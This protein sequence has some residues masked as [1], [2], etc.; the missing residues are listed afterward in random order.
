MTYTIQSRAIRSIPITLWFYIIG[1]LSVSLVSAL[2]LFVLPNS[3]PQIH[4]VLWAL[5]VVV[6]IFLR[7]IYAK[8]IFL[9]W[10]IWYL[11]GVISY[12][13]ANAAHVGILSRYQADPEKFSLIYLVFL[14]AAVVGAY[15]TDRFY[16]GAH[17]QPTALK[18]RS[19]D[20]F[21][22]LALLVFSLVYAFT[23]YLGAGGFPILSGVNVSASMYENN[24]SPLKIFSF[25]CSIAAISVYLFVGKQRPG[26]VPCA[27]ILMSIFCGIVDG[28]RV[29]GL[30]AIMGIALVAYGKDQTLKSRVQ[31]ALLGFIAIVFYVGLS[32]LR[33]GSGFDQNWPVMVAAVGVEFRDSIFLANTYTPEAIQ[34][35]GYQWGLSTF[36]SMTNRLVLSLFGIDKDSA[37]LHDSA[38]TLMRYMNVLLGIRVGIITEWW[39]AFGWWG[40]APMAALGSGFVV[41]S[42][43]ASK[44]AS[45]I[46]RLI[47][48]SLLS[49]F[50]MAIMGQS[51]VTFGLIPTTLYICLGLIIVRYI[52]ASVLATLFPGHAGI[53]LP[54]WMT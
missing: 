53:R 26:L 47:L 1:I 54:R 18:L 44:A 43:W 21:V 51:T 4:I 9:F 33:S 40:V 23:T 19:G 31:I 27:L 36:A 6:T 24:Y 29:F 3:I 20:I 14:L 42:R 48:I 10:E 32:L 25:A 49:L 52:G 34:S 22:V 12:S 2:I 7:S 41:L 30:M 13:A 38:R 28:R 15:V 37:I 17:D 11:V 45:L 16:R 39:F 8:A 5:A 35:G 50:A 46:S